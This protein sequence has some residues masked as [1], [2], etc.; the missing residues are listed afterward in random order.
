MVAEVP[1]FTFPLEAG[2]ATADLEF[3]AGTV[4]GA[5]LT[6]GQQS[7]PCWVELP[8]KDASYNVLKSDLEIC[9]P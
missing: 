2:P 7:D 8:Q 4:A 1:A 6:R 9:F 3:L 5:S